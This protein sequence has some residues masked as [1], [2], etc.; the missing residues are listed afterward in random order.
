M[1]INHLF[2][3]NRAFNTQEECWE[4][5]PCFAL[6]WLGFEFLTRFTAKDNFKLRTIQTLVP[7]NFFNPEIQRIGYG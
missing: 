2:K 7:G 6:Y 4:H 3:P 1:F 5:F